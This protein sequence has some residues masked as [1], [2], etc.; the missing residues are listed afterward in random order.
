VGAAGG[1]AS[2][3]P[4]S[5]ATTQLLLEDRSGNNVD[6]TN[7]PGTRDLWVV[8]DTAGDTA[9][10]RLDVD[11]PSFAEVHTIAAASLPDP[12]AITDAADGQLWVLGA[13]GNLVPVDPTG[14]PGTT[15]MFAAPF[16]SYVSATGVP[17]SAAVFLMR[18]TGT[19]TAV[20]RFDI[21]GG[22]VTFDF[23]TLITL[24]DAASITDAPG[25]RLALTGRGQANA[26]L[27]VELD[28]GTG[29]LVASNVCL[30]FPGSYVSITDVSEP[31]PATPGEAG[32]GD[33][34]LLVTGYDE[35]SGE[36]ALLYGAACEANDH[37]IH[38]GPLTRE[39]LATYNYTG[40]DC[41]IGSTGIYEQFAPGVDSLFFVLV[42]DDGTVEGSYGRDSALVE[43]APD[44]ANGS[45]P[46]PQDLS[47]ACLP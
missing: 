5:G 39:D 29:D 27:Y 30:D 4:A 6:L 25:G 13:S 20:D 17:G 47:A 33:L 24:D 19:T 10:D 36:L 31:S 22:T 18:D 43:R 14:G 41:G 42:A 11:T 16:G 9:I 8:R 28:A 32:V 40:R 34:P 38:F 3:D 26:P 21:A 1:Y 37:T 46:L 7:L 35:L 44:L 15:V 2:A 45:C 12:V 23:A